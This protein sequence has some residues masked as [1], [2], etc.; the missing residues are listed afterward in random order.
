M[1]KYRNEIKSTKNMSLEIYNK[2][3]INKINKSKKCN[4]FC[5]NLIQNKECKWYDKGICRFAHSIEDFN[6]SNILKII[7]FGIQG[8]YDITVLKKYNIN[9]IF[10]YADTMI[11]SSVRF[12]NKSI[13]LDYCKEQYEKLHMFTIKKEKEFK[14]QNELLPYHINNHYNNIINFNNKYDLFNCSELNDIKRQLKEHIGCKICYKTII[15]FG[16]NNYENISTYYD[17]VSL[18]CGHTICNSC[19]IDIINN[20]SSIYINCPICRNKNKLDHTN[21]NYELNEQYLKIKIL[22][23]SFSIMFNKFEKHIKLFNKNKFISINN[24]KVNSY[25]APW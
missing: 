10:N 11:F 24:N 19:H 6:K 16:D 5:N 23:K 1:E 14:L 4:K 17:F 25:E 20:T 15:N 18:S 21:P 22:I 2:Y 8:Y 7:E 9:N 13:Q 12:D 3:F